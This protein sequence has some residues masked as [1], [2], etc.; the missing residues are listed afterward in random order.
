MSEY[1]YIEFRAIDSPVSEKNLAYMQRQS[2][3]AEITAWSFVNE[4]HYGDFRGDAIEM[5]RRGYDIHLHYANY[6]IRSLYFRLPQGLPDS[7]AAKPYLNDDS[8][9]FVKDRDGSGGTLVIE[10]CYEPGDLEDLWGLDEVLD[11][12][13]PLRAEI[14]DGD[15]RPLYLARLAVSCDMNHDPE[16]ETEAPVPAGLGQ[17]TK[18][19]RAL[20]EFYEISDALLAA[21]AR[22]AAPL[23]Q[24]DDRHAGFAEWVGR[25]SEDVKNNWLTELAMGSDRKLRTEILA[26]FRTDLPTASWPTTRADRTVAEL[27]AAAAEIQQ[28]R[29]KKSVEDRVRK[30]NRE[31]AKMAANPTPYLTKTEQLVAERSTTAYAQASQMLADLR[32]ALAETGRSAI[33]EKQAQKLKQMNPTLRHLT[34]ALRRQGF[35]PKQEV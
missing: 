34:A 35:L 5:L 26:K 16:E 25:Q 1:Q 10:P 2:S 4:Y 6:G 33:A 20:A 24:N 27:M 3:R 17:L 14:L 13:V 12:F 19:Q 15:L 21:A 8:L 29:D 28:A 9:R 32:E 7:K 18:A 23:V 22:Q 31:L 30:R 11:R